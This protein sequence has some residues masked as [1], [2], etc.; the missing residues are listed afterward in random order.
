MSELVDFR[1]LDSPPLQIRFISGFSLNSNAHFL[2]T[3]GYSILFFLLQF[4]IIKGLKLTWKWKFL[5]ALSLLRVIILVL[6]CCSSLIMNDADVT[7]VNLEMKVFMS[8][9]LLWL[10]FNLSLLAQNG[11]WVKFYHVWPK[12]DGEKCV[13]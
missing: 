7:Q 12:N 3:F 11:I 6:F 1:F 9:H 4:L 10:W 2:R 13:V 8:Q 5:Y